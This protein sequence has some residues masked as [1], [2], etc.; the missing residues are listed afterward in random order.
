MCCLSAVCPDHGSRYVLQ[1]T[2]ELII[3][4]YP[5]F[6]PIQRTTTIR[7]RDLDTLNV[8]IRFAVQESKCRHGETNQTST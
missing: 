5:A 3:Y 2:G 4:P 7:A 8:P 6:A 1:T